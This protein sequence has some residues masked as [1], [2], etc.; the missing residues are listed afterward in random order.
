MLKNYCNPHYNVIP[1]SNNLHS[2]R[3]PRI[4]AEAKTVLGSDPSGNGRSRC[5]VPCAE[6]HLIPSIT[7]RKIKDATGF[8]T[9]FQKCSLKLLLPSSKVE[10]RK[11]YDHNYSHS[12]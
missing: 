11:N 2:S 5:G 4:L 7:K 8:L 3:L 10:H 1:L 12:H 9:D 6:F